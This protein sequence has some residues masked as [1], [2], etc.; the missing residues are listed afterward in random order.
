MVNPRIYIPFVL[1]L[2]MLVRSFHPPI[3]RKTS[4]TG[5]VLDWY[6]GFIAR[7]K[8]ILSQDNLGGYTPPVRYIIYKFIEGRKNN[9][10]GSY[11]IKLV[12]WRHVFPPYRVISEIHWTICVLTM[13]HHG[14]V[15]DQKLHNDVCWKEWNK[16]YI[17]WG[18]G[19]FLH[20]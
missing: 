6:G 16:W 1:I 8:V 9:Y 2:T 20:S 12:L 7:S 11:G 14:I 18:F 13:L 4:I 19:K 10:C 15:W 3:H 17:F 5:L